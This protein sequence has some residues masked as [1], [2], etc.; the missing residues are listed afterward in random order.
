MTDENVSTLSFKAYCLSSLKY[1]AASSLALGMLACIL[2]FL[3]G[4][5]S[6]NFEIGLEIDRLDGLWVLFGLPVIAILLLVVISPLSF[7]IY[8][9]LRRT[10][11]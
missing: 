1:T 4:E 9:T 10:V 2:I 7:F 5:T 3:V 8:K 6:M 11:G